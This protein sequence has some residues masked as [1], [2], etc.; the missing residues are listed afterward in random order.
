MNLSTTFEKKKC[1][2]SLYSSFST[3]LKKKIQFS[4][5][6]GRPVDLFAHASLLFIIKF[7]I[8]Y[9][10]RKKKKKKKKKEKREVK[11]SLSFDLCIS[12][13]LISI[14]RMRAA[15]CHNIAAM[16]SAFKFPKRSMILRCWFRVKYLGTR[17]MT[18]FYSQQERQ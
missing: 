4:S 17:L 2:P 18:F 1:F 10:W 13:A 16:T 11:S 9:F 5:A 14:P 7:L 8:L 3:D 12:V 15:T 6:L